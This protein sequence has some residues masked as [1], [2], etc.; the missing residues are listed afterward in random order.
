MG[1]D[2]SSASRARPLT[3]LAATVAL[4]AGCA[5][6]LGI[7]TWRDPPS[8]GGGGSGDST[9]GSAGAAST[10]SAGGRPPVDPENP[11]CADRVKNGLETDVDCG[12][13]ACPP[14]ANGERCD[15]DADCAGLGCDSGR[16]VHRAESPCEKGTG[17]PTCHD[18][19]K[20]GLETDVDCGGD[21]CPPCLGGKKCGNDADC[22]SGRCDRDLCA[23]GHVG[24]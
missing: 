10:S 19:K 4:A 21:A 23:D 9:S 20:N 8:G 22:D 15:N 16:C 17:G 1:R 13:D 24:I 3:I 18:C 12:G 11:T 14:C 5:N 6:V 2:R 7:E